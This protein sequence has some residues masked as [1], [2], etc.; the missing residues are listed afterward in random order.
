LDQAIAD[1]GDAGVELENAESASPISSGT[2]PG[3]ASDRRRQS[4]AG[5]RRIGHGRSNGQIKHPGAADGAV[6]LLVAEPGEAIIPA[7]PEM[8]LQAL[9]QAWTSFNLRED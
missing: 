9:G 1:V 4:T 8:T 3:R 5:C 2:D 6:A 7:Q